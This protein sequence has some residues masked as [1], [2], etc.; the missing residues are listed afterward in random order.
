MSQ[1]E[2]DSGDEDDAL[3]DLQMLA[4]LAAIDAANNGRPR[5]PPR[6]RLRLHWS[7]FRRLRVQDG[8]F[9]RMFRVSEHQFDEL[10]RIL[11]PYLIADEDMARLATSAGPVSPE[12][13]VAG[14]L[15][16]L[17]GASYLDM[18]HLLG[19]GVSTYYHCVLQVVAA[20]NAAE[21]M[22]FRFPETVQE[23]TELARGFE[24]TSA[25]GAFKVLLQ[26]CHTLIICNAHGMLRVLVYH[27][28]CT[29]LCRCSGR[30]SDQDSG[31][32]SY[33]ECQDEELLL[34]QAVLQSQRSSYV[35]FA[36]QIHCGVHCLPR[37]LP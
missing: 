16:Y 28:S 32:T 36:D 13:R 11:E 30:H 8:T 18:F 6:E 37:R 34:S 27:W 17:A 3:A 35:R 2:C 19:M 24:A 10:V 1:P 5:R 31:P 22:Q 25:Y 4:V 23:C 33:R 12:L 14:A 15:R 9:K 29:V 20:I 26:P 7:E 21:R